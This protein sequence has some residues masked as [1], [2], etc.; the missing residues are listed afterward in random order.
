MAARRTGRQ[1]ITKNTWHA[2]CDLHDHPHC[3]RCWR[4]DEQPLEAGGGARP[5]AGRRR[6]PLRRTA[7]SFR[8]SCRSRSV[9][10]ATDFED[11]TV[12]A[13]SLTWSSNIDWT[14]GHRVRRSRRSALALGTHTITLSAIDALGAIGT[15]TRTITIA[16]NQA[17]TAAITRPPTTRHISSGASVTLLG[18]GSDPE[19]GALEWRVA[20]MDEQP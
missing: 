16:A 9:G 6:S 19:D 3:D 18:N 5:A 10:S 17:P 11:G 4:P 1:P 12:P 13:S 7:V 20:R 14:A 8:S 15:A 2:A